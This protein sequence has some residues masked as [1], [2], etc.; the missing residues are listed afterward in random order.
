MAVKRRGNV[1]IE[2]DYEIKLQKSI[3]VYA[4]LVKQ[5]DNAKSKTLYNLLDEEISNFVYLSNL[6][7]KY[8]SLYVPKLTNDNSTSDFLNESLERIKQIEDK[9]NARI[10]FE[11][12][13]KKY[14][15]MQALD[16]FKLWS[17]DFFV[18]GF[19]KAISRDFKDWS[20]FT[21]LMANNIADLT[22]KAIPGVSE[23]KGI[24]DS[25]KNAADLINEFEKNGTD[26]S[27]VDKKLTEI[28]VHIE[29]M[30]IAKVNY[31]QLVAAL[32]GKTDT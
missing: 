13:K 9:E 27:D 29:I 25:V 20:E 14:E 7:S 1:K 11:D 2:D 31:E 16:K 5:R 24:Y 8:I 19:W 12:T 23:I 6:Y 3:E 30:N 22:S 26:Y 15:L 32:E 10:L 4:D 21:K 17:L 18:E 28:E